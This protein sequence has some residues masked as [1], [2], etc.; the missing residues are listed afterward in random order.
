MSTTVLLVDD[1]EPF[2]HALADLIGTTPDIE[3][4]GAIG[5]GDAAVDIAN[6]V[7]PDVIV[8]DLELTGVNG[9]E[10]IRQVLA[11]DPSARV[12]VVSMHGDR[13][14]RERARLVGAY[15]YLTK[16]ST[17]AELLEAIRAVAAGE[18]VP[19]TDPDGPTPTS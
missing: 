8:S 7:R 16:D 17:P 4:V 1:H 13:H 3:L 10:V 14:L 6:R 15:G 19:G 5:D 18:P 2:R 9:I 12:L 11:D